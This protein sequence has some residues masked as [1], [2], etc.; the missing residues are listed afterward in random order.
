[1]KKATIRTIVITNKQMKATE[2]V[3][4]LLTRWIT[5][6]SSFINP[7]I[8]CMFL[9][10]DLW[11]KSMALLRVCWI[12]LTRYYSIIYTFN[13]DSFNPTLTFWFWNPCLYRRLR[14][15]ELLLCTTNFLFSKRSVFVVQQPVYLCGISRRFTAD[16]VFDFF[17]QSVH[18]LCG[19]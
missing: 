5:T 7:S 6:V 1:M 18:G 15:S 13:C 8:S 2:I 17:T 9:R 16:S 11:K 3:A 19:N 10:F 14:F 12:N 4:F